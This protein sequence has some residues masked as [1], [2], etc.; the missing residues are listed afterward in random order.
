MQWTST[1][2]QKT[3]WKA[4]LKCTTGSVK[5]HSAKGNEIHFGCST[6]PAAPPSVYNSV[7]TVDG[8]GSASPKQVAAF[9][10]RL[11]PREAM[12]PLARTEPVV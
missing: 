1:N 4:I 9:R 8:S 6:L 10:E 2:I 3:T 12:E 7:V 5:V 11:V